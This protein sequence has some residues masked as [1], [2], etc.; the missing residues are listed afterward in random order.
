MWRALRFSLKGLVA[1][2]RFESSFR[3]ELYLLLFLGPCAIWL[4][5]SG[6]ERALLLGSLLLVLV[7]ELLN[8]AIETVIERYGAEPH[9]LAGRA[10]DLGSAAVFV[11]M[12]NSVAVWSLVLLS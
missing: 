2:W 4:G 10:K 9:E 5:E 12:L 8:T 6:L 3:L 11:A 7:A 1:A